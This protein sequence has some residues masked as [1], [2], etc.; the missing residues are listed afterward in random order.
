MILYNLRI[1]ESTYRITKFDDDMNVESSYLVSDQACECPQGHKPTCRHRKMLPAL[2][3]IVDTEE[4]YC[5]DNR[6]YYGI[7]GL[8]HA[9]PKSGATARESEGAMP[10]I[11]SYV[12]IKED[13]DIVTEF[14]KLIDDS[15][16]KYGA[17][18]LPQHIRQR[19]QS[20]EGAFES[21]AVKITQDQG[22][23]PIE[24]IKRRI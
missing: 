13:Q 10:T 14:G 21:G 17:T 19:A 16:G 15:S 9:K 20:L 12:E 4:F 22:Q 18:D 1:V 6:M 11:A 24:R 3:P 5:Y 7:E 8:G 2:L 23:A